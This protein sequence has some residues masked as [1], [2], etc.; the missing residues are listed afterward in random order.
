ML[1][2]EIGE[3]A[4]ADPLGMEPRWRLFGCWSIT[5][6]NAT[7]NPKITI[8]GLLVNPCPVG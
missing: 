4:Y 5:V 2:S 1:V 7:N 8:P 6:G 3:G